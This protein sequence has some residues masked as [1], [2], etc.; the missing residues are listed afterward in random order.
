MT[1]YEG[2]AAGRY[3]GPSTRNNGIP[4][5]YAPEDSPVPAGTRDEGAYLLRHRTYLVDADEDCSMGY[6]NEGWREAN[7]FF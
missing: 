7:C 5:E 1:I 3:W 2:T 6:A 4:S